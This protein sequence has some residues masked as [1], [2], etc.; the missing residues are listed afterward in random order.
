M[1]S[2]FRLKA[3]LFLVTVLLWIG[4]DSLPRPLQKSN[5]IKAS[6]ITEPVQY[7]TDDPA[8]W[9][10]PTAPESTLILGTD[11]DTDGALV[12]FDI[13]GKIEQGRT[14][15]GLK[16][17]NNVDIEYGFQYG[18]NCIDIAVVTE[19]EANR[20]RVFRLPDMTAIDGGGLPVFVG[21]KN[22]APMG[23]ALYKR[24]HDG[25]VFAILSRKHGPTNGG[26]LWQYHL[27]AKQNTVIASHIRSFGRFSGAGEIEAIAVDDKLGFIYYSDEN[28]GIRKYGADPDGEHGNREL[29]L[30]G[31]EGFEED[32]EGISLYCNEDS[33]GYILVSDQQADRFQVF[34]RE[35]MPNK[36]HEHQPIASIPL[37]T[38]ESDGSEVLSDS[39]GSQYPAGI[40]V[41]MSDDRTFQFYD[42]RD[43]QHVIDSAGR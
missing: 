3:I 18:D 13:E 7:D 25:Q 40:F 30:F 31:Q 27:D 8:I 15:R 9:L 39:I 11:K 35:G 20:L 17:P 4:C 24:P 12:V 38:Q 36:P 23:I 19:R 43:L 2:I 22:R 21:E 41:A 37:S 6:R 26:Y 34:P 5:R 33:S 28:A 32:R 10:H 14:V 42:W 1:Q 16:R 29:A